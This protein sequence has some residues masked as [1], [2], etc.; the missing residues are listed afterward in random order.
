M[1]ISKKVHVFG[2]EFE[3]STLSNIDINTHFVCQ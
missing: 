2:D 1:K 3:N